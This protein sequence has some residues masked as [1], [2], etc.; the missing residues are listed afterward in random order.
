[1]TQKTEEIQVEGLT[2]PVKIWKLNYGFGT[3]IEDFFSDIKQSDTG[4]EMT[5]KPGKVRLGWL[6]FGIY[7]AE[8]IGIPAPKS[9]ADGL[10]S[11]ELKQRLRAARGMDRK[12]GMDIYDKILELN[13]SESE[14]EHSLEEIQKK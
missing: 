11:A 4:R 9:I 6:A 1:M 3:D 5:I 10:S 14:P 2:Q 13:N 8:E 12:R 7:E